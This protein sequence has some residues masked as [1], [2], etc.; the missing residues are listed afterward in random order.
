[1]RGPLSLALAWLAPARALACPDCATIRAARTA[2][3][4]DPRLWI[5]IAST[6]TPFLVLA[7]VAALAHRARPSPKLPTP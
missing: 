1:M 4:A 2:I 3:D 5:F 6:V 7:L